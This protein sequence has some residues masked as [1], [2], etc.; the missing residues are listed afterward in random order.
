MASL[1]VGTLI[2]QTLLA[3]SFDNHHSP[4]KSKN[5]NHT[6]VKDH[7]MEDK[8][9]VCGSN[10]LTDGLLRFH[11]SPIVCIK[12]GFF[13]LLNCFQSRGSIGIRPPGLP[14]TRRST[15]DTPACMNSH[16][17][18]NS[19]SA[20]QFHQSGTRSYQPHLRGAQLHRLDIEFQS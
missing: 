10:R 5:Q 8:P 13:K 12:S 9:T 16:V 14:Y 19:S 3:L 17:L 1:N 6:S 18:R 11:V 15:P 20:L 4:H 2:L 7:Q